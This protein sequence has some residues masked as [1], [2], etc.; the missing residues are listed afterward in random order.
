[1]RKIAC[2]FAASIVAASAAAPASAAMVDWMEAVPIVVNAGIES[3]LVLFGFNPQP[4]PPPAGL[5]R[6]VLIDPTFAEQALGGIEPQPF[7]LF[8]AASGGAFSAP[9]EPVMDFSMLSV[10]FTTVGGQDLTF[11]FAFAP[12]GD[13]DASLGISDPLFFNP[14]PEPPPIFDDAFGLQFAFELMGVEQ[15]SI[16]LQALDDQGQAL[17]LSAVPLPPALGLLAAAA[18]V[19]AI[20]SRG[21]ARRA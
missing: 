9:S 14:Q 13:G 21:G 6:S 11:R 20:V 4:E 19:G 18:A 5:S 3:P 15:A 17:G 8:V 2:G 12:D 1:M 7:L 10:G 16:R